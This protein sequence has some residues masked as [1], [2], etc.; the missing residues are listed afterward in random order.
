MVLTNK[1]V[2][3]SYRDKWIDAAFDFLTAPRRRKCH[4]ALHAAARLFNEGPRLQRDALEA[5]L[6]T[7]EPVDLVARRCSLPTSV[8]E[9]YAQTFCDVRP[10]LHA[11]DWIVRHLIGA[12]L[13]TGFAEKDI[14]SV[15]KLFGL[16]GG[17]RIL[18][19]IVSVC[20]QDGL[21]DGT[22][23]LYLTAPPVF[24]QQV[25]R[26]AR[27]AVD[28]LMLPANTKLRHLADLLTHARHAKARP[29]ARSVRDVVADHADRVLESAAM[30]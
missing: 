21:V 19:V 2:P 25:R 17:V 6:L 27:L 22:D 8:A 18:D 11:R 30:T 29:Q 10:Q 5:Y 1:T 13:W 26:K 28:A 14:G 3:A 24:D 16:N 7:A 12:N 23:H 9:V 20:V 4:A 15:W